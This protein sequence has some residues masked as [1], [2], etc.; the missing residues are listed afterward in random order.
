MGTRIFQQMAMVTIFLLLVLGNM[1]FAWGGPTGLRHRSS[2]PTEA[3]ALC[4]DGL[5]GLKSPGAGLKSVWQ[6]GLQ[7]ASL[8]SSGSTS[9]DPR[10][11]V[12]RKGV[13]APIGKLRVH[14]EAGDPRN[15]L[16][17]QSGSRE[18][19]AFLISPCYILATYHGTF[20]TEP[21]PKRD[22][23]FKGITFSVGKG[24]GDRF[25]YE[26]IEAEPIF[27]GGWA[28]G[29]DSRGNPTSGGPNSDYAIL[30]LKP[31]KTESC[32]GEDPEIGYFELVG[33]G[34]EPGLQV[35]TAGYPHDRDRDQLSA[36]RSCRIVRRSSDRV[37]KKED[38]GWEND[39][40]TRD[41]SSGQPLFYLDEQRGVPRVVAMIVAS[42][43]GEDGTPDAVSIAG[44]VGDADDASMDKIIDDLD[45]FEVGGRENPQV[46]MARKRTNPEFAE[47][48]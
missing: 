31:L 16:V 15:P 39:C 35:M 24:S 29:R 36:Q 38:G 12:N 32:P 48:R 8:A 6:Q 45:R 10:E 21:K 44:S 19:T 1:Q 3:Q 20:G 18:T 40:T 37:T 27:W 14:F 47:L 43:H 13:F 34:A 2:E 5:C 26:N 17:G 22:R 30:K 33:G 25:K 42:E 41:G 7:L 9:H 23:D 46:V 11:Y 4:A 28:S